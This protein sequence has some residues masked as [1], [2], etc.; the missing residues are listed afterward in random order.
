MGDFVKTITYNIPG[1]FDFD[2]A[3]VEVATGAR[4]K[5]VDNAAQFFTQPFDNDTGHTYDNTKAEFTGGQVQ[6]IDNLPTNSVAWITYTNNIDINY[7]LSGTRTGT[8]AGGAAISGNRLDC[9]NGTSKNVSYDNAAIATLGDTLTVKFIYTPDYTGSPPANRGMIQIGTAANRVVLF[10]AGTGQFRLSAWDSGNNPIHAAVNLGAAYPVTSGNTYEMSLNITAS[11]GVIELYIKGIYQGATPVTTFTRTATTGVLYVGGGISYVNSDAY[12]EDVVLYNT[13]QHSGG[14][15]GNYTPGYTLAEYRYV[16]S[17]GAI[18][19]FTYGGVGNIQSYDGL[20]TSESNAPHYYINNGTNDY[21][22]NG[23]TWA[24]SDGSYAQSNDK[25][26]FDTNISSFTAVDN[27][28]MK[29]AFDNGDSQM[30]ISNL[31]LEYTGQIYTTGSQP[32]IEPFD[33]TDTDGITT[34]SAVINVSGADELKLTMKVNGVEKYWTGTAWANSSGYSQS[35]TIDQLTDAAMQALT[36]EGNGIEFLPKVYFNSADG[37]TTPEILSITFEY[38]YFEPPDT[39]P[40]TCKIPQYFID[41]DTDPIEGVQLIWELENDDYPTGT[42]YSNPNSRVTWY[43]DASGYA[44][45]KLIPTALYAGGT[46]YK[47]TRIIGKERDIWT[48]VTVPNQDS[49]DYEAVL[50]TGE[51]QE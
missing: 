7:S 40:A 4:L 9:T 8:A 32:S 3:I 45:M 43:S 1:N 34:I 17:N 18:P 11:T 16:A 19:Q 35:N 24:V 39:T 13:V 15:G 14:A 50:A 25:A 10:H 51:K 12:F 46:T 5:K 42:N 22:W 29:W 27:P 2:A 26:T 37:S 30:A 20:T 48:G 44:E 38:N 49:A 23:S 41:P 33:H 6:Q 28:I 47:H 21:Y 36:S 31:S